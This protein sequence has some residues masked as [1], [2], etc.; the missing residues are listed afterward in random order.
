MV[1]Q[2]ILDVLTTPRDEPDSSKVKK[3]PRYTRNKNF[4]H[5]D[6]IEDW[7]EFTFENVHLAFK[8]FL[9]QPVPDSFEASSLP[10]DIEQP[11][12]EHVFK[13][14]FQQSTSKTVKEAAEIVMKRFPGLF[15][16]GRVEM[17][18]E[19]SVY[20]PDDIQLPDVASKKP[21]PRPHVIPDFVQ[22]Y[23]PNKQQ[24]LSENDE[25]G[26]IP[27]NTVLQDKTVLIMGEGKLS[28]GWS[29]DRLAKFLEAPRSAEFSAHP[30]TLVKRAGSCRVSKLTQTT[31]TQQGTRATTKRKPIQQPTDQLGTYCVWGKV[32]FGF[33]QTEREFLLC[34]TICIRDPDTNTTRAGMKVARISWD[35]EYRPNTITPELALFCVTLAALY[36]HN[37]HNNFPLTAYSHEDIITWHRVAGQH[38]PG[39][40]VK[41]RNKFSGLMHPYSELRK[42]KHLILLKEED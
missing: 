38:G 37:R 34:N 39:K 10:Q 23:L 21:T 35:T 15:P 8:E 33:L 11:E 31:P 29:F 27:Q 42:H 26:T 32:P 36:R 41:Y 24:S 14:M 18:P 6:E 12:N 13:I 1:N 2:T 28:T 4:L 16:P 5:T 30:R 25:G 22:I 17:H 19:C 3:S 9:D 7:A 20:K 40:G